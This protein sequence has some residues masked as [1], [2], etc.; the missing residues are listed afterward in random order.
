MGLK[1]F[2][3]KIGILFE[4]LNQFCI[5]YLYLICAILLTRIIECITLWATNYQSRIIENILLGFIVDIAYIG[6]IVAVLYIIYFLL[7]KVSHKLANYTI[8]TFFWAY[9]CLSILLSLYFAVSHIPLDSIITVYS[10]KELY[11]TVS[12]NNPY[13]IPAVITI[14]ILSISFIFIPRKKIC[15]A[16]WLQAT[17]ITL[18]LCFIFFPGLNKEKFKFNKEY[19][20][21]ENKI[22]YLIESIIEDYSVIMLSDRELR[23]KSSE[24]ASYFPEYEFINYKYP[25]LHKDISPDVL[26][27]YFEIG[28][29]KPNIVIIIGEGLCTHISGKNSIAASATP[30]LDSL[31]EHS[32][33]WENCLSTSERT[34]GVLPSIFGAL[35]FGNKGFMTYR[36]DMPNFTSIANILYDNGYK[37]TFFYGGWYGFDCMDIFAENNHMSMFYNSQEHES[38]SQRNSWGLYDEY[39]LM[40]SIPD[41]KNSNAQPRFDTYLTLTTHDPFEYPDKE[42][43][44][45]LYKQRQNEQPN[46]Q[47]TNDYYSIVENAS[48]MY[49]DNCLRKFFNEYSKCKSFNNTIFII[50]GDHKFQTENEG[51]AID[52][53]RVPLIIWSPMLKK[54]QTFKALTTH[55]DI[56][57]SILK[58]LKNNYSVNI[59]DNGI[60]LNSGLDTSINFTTKTF[61]PH[62]GTNRKIKGITY[63]EYL[64]TD[65]H[66][67]KYYM[68]DD[69]LLLKQ[70]D[71]NA[72]LKYLLELYQTLD[73]YI[74]GNDALVPY[75]K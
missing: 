73:K 24:L 8:R 41:I 55:R 26:S 28:E 51:F 16:K 61:S 34:F 30:F 36:H 31:S 12:A 44:I 6:W 15:F 33:T 46:K 48:F 3:E 17:M 13:N 32:L 50:T 14:I 18:S 42:Y 10:A 64:I 35:P 66:T 49:A 23:E 1:R 38:S 58:F 72:K 75:D 59:P 54:S 9:I 68:Q 52:N 67:Y 25:L 47:N 27:E 60:W 45:D 5:E 43:Y 69:R 22:K 7:T 29:S 74:M 65:T 57:P 20:I 70:V 37:N 39:I 40:N 11:V 21:V 53:F 4:P 63:N 19:Y 62:V 2:R 71:N 56:A